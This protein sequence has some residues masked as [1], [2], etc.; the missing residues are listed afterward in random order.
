M[1]VFIISLICYKNGLSIHCT[2]QETLPYTLFATTGI[3]LTFALSRLI[4]KYKVKKIFYYIGQET[5]IILSLHFL[6]FKLVTIILIGLYKI[7][8]SHLAE[9]PVLNINNMNYWYIY[10][11]CGIIIPLAIKNVYN[12]TKY[13]IL[14]KR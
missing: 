1:V 9:Y 10:S 3:Y 4:D 8:I 2:Y 5:M 7:P 13:N 12:K 14:W 11:L 6:S